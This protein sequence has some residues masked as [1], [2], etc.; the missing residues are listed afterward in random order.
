VGSYSFGSFE[1]EIIRSLAPMRPILCPPEIFKS[2]TKLT[3]A[4]AKKIHGSAEK[5]TRASAKKIHGSE[6]KSRKLPKINK[7]F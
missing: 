1:E 7:D 2:E 5:L 4:S 3:R 6:E